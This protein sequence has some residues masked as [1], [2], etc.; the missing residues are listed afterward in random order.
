MQTGR[1]LGSTRDYLT[2]EAFIQQ[3][4]RG[5]GKNI[6]LGILRKLEFCSTLK[7]AGLIIS[8]TWDRPLPGETQWA[9]GLVFKLYYLFCFTQKI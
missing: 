4:V 9:G 1:Y 2:E 8:K 7:A 3:N 6:L 5:N